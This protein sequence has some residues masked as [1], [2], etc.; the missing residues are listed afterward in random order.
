MT[1]RSHWTSVLLSA[2]LWLSPAL[3]QGPANYREL[4]GTVTDASHEPL[5]GAV[6]QL[7]ND[8]TKFTLSF[9][10]GK[11]GHYSFQRTNGD[12]NYHVWASFR[13]HESAKHSISPFDTN[14]NKVIDL[15]IRLD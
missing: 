12:A 14:K 3:A 6:V 11:D 5:R 4:S 8:D 2:C 9:I 1:Q 7:H 13:S 10:T 15:E